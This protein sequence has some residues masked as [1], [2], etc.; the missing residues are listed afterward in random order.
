M[1]NK[2]YIA[3]YGNDEFIILLPETE[4]KEAC[5]AGT[6]LMELV[7]KIKITYKNKVIPITIS[8]AVTQ[9]YSTDKHLSALNDRLHKAMFEAKKGAGQVF[10]GKPSGLIKATGKKTMT[11]KSKE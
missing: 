5:E 2:D 8:I 10:C 3:R 7:K 1:R 9:S 11:K 6:Y 4:D